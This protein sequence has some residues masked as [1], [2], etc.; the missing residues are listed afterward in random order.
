[1]LKIHKHYAPPYKL[2]R[3][4]DLASGSCA[5]LGQCLDFLYV[6]LLQKCGQEQSNL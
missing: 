1:M 2:S 5:R 4:G 3:P 6:E